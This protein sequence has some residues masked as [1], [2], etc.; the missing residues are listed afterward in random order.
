[1]KKLFASKT[2]RIL[3]SLLV[4][5]IAVQSFIESPI[6]NSDFRDI[7]VSYSSKVIY[8]DVYLNRPVSCEKL[9]SQMDIKPLDVRN[10]TYF[11]TCKVF[12]D[13]LRITYTEN[14][15]T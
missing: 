15:R 4:V 5:V 11:P 13:G 10:V 8:L 3:L 9:M 2:L 12:D 14:Y 6:Q 7:K 1:M